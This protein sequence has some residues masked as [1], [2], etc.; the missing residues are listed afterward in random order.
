MQTIAKPIKIYA[1]D[2]KGK[3]VT[4]L[5]DPTDPWQCTVSVQSGPGGSVMGTTTVSF[6]D[7]IAT[8]DDIHIDQSGTGYILQFDIS[9]PSTSIVGAMSETFDVA[10]R[11]LGLM[12][13]TESA[14]IAQN[15]TF[16]VTATIWDDALDQPAD[17]SVLTAALLSLTELSVE[18]QK[19]LSLLET[20]SSPL[21]T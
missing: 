8:F 18:P 1:K 14:L 3:Q 12:F 15:T 13:T 4:E 6:I 16:S 2:S 11:P 20:T 5:G 17:T 21:T 19:S 9:Y 10:G 7:G